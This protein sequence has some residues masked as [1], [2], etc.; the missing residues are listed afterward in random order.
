M[1]N[2]RGE[3]NIVGGD[4]VDQWENV[5]MIVYLIRNRYRGSAV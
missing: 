1:G 4:S 3:V 2:S 5:R